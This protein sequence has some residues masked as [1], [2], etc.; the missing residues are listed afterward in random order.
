MLILE[1]GCQLNLNLSV[2][3]NV[4]SASFMHGTGLHACH[5]LVCCS[6]TDANG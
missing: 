3:T 5:M 4:F 6:I 1:L 2:D